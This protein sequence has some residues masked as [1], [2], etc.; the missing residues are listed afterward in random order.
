MSQF[1][2]IAMFMYLLRMGPALIFIVLMIFLFFSLKVTI[3]NDDLQRFNMELSDALSGTKLASDRSVFSAAE[4]NKLETTKEV[5][6]YARY[7]DYGY[8]VEIESLIDKEA[9]CEN[10]EPCTGFCN[11]ACGAGSEC[12]C[13]VEVFGT[14]FC[15]CKKGDEW[16]SKH[17]WKFG[18]DPESYRE[19]EDNFAKTEGGLYE[20][21]FS[22][23]PASIDTG[24]DVTQAELRL[25]T[26]DSLLTRMTCAVQKAYETKT[27]AR[28][29]FDPSK[30][31]MLDPTNAPSIIFHRTD[32]DGTHVCL[33][34]N[35]DRMNEVAVQCRY[36]PDIPVK[37][38]RREWDFQMEKFKF[39][40]AYPMKI[41]DATCPPKEE[42]IA[43]DGE[44][45]TVMLCVK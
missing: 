9:F 40:E 11:S 19:F 42:D 44:V 29:N 43:T 7:C 41:E 14:N 27:V 25:T 36:M 32:E 20:K 17:T 12:R 34:Q 38:L 37:E 21:T 30:I 2:P 5:E 31:P 6:L 16:I 1:E 10:G 18:N 24:D 8:V 15:Q 28:I 4:L 39:I 33:Y 23:F 3:L 45:A 22:T 13:N 26:Y 35:D